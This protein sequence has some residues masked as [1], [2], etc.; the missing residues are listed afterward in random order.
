MRVQL[1]VL[2]I[3]LAGYNIY[4]SSKLP[5]GNLKRKYSSRGKDRETTTLKT[6]TLF[7]LVLYP[8]RGYFNFGQFRHTSIIEYKK[9]Y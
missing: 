4:L 1:S 9:Y 3:Y 6:L 7:L 2:D 5:I 8:Y